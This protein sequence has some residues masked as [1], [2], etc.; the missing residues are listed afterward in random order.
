[1]PGIKEAV[2]EFCQRGYIIEEYKYSSSGPAH[3]PVFQCTLDLDLKRAGNFRATGM[4]RNKQEAQAECAGEMA[5]L[6]YNADLFELTAVELRQ[7][8][9]GRS[10]NESSFM[11]ARYTVPSHSTVSSTDAP[12]HSFAPSPSVPSPPIARTLPV[13]PAATT[14]HADHVY[15]APSSHPQSPASSSYSNFNTPGPQPPYNPSQRST[16]PFAPPHNAPE[17]ASFPRT[18]SGN[19]PSLTLRRLDSHRQTLIELQRI[20]GS[21]LVV[22]E[23]ERRA[24]GPP[25]MPAHTSRLTGKI[26]LP[27]GELPL[28]AAYTQAR[29]KD[30]DNLC[31]ES[32]LVQIEQAFA[33][34]NGRGQVKR[35]PD[36]QAAS[37]AP[38]TQ[39]ATP[40]GYASGAPPPPT[41]SYNTHAFN[42][43]AHVQNT[44]AQ[45]NAPPRHHGGY[46]ARNYGG[47]YDDG[48]YGG[49]HETRSYGQ[50]R[51]HAGFNDPRGYGSHDMHAQSYDN[52]VYAQGGGF[53]P[54][55]SPVYQG[56]WQRSSSSDPYSNSNSNSNTRSPYHYNNDSTSGYDGYNDS[57]HSG[58]PGNY[59]APP[60]RPA[61]NTPNTYHSS[62]P[63]YRHD[64][65]PQAAF[66]PQAASGAPFLEPDLQ[67]NEAVF[68]SESGADETSQSITSPSGFVSNTAKATLLLYCTRVKARPAEFQ[69][70][71]KQI[72]PGV[73]GVFVSKVSVPGHGEDFEGKTFTGVAEASR[74]SAAENLAAMNLLEQLQQ[75]DLLAPLRVFPPSQTAPQERDPNEP[76]LI[77]L[78]DHL[79]RELAALAGDFQPLPATYTRNTGTPGI[80]TAV[81]ED[82]LFGDAAGSV[83]QGRGGRAW[84]TRVVSPPTE[85]DQVRAQSRLECQLD[86][87]IQQLDAGGDLPPRFSLPTML[88]ADEITKIVEQ[89]DVT[90]VTGATGSGKTTQVPQ[91]ILDKYTQDGNGGRCHI[92]VTE[93]RRIAAIG[94]AARVAEERGET[95]GQSVGYFVRHDSQLPP[96]IAGTIVFCTSGALL[97]RLAVDPT[98]VGVTHLILDEVHERDIASDFTLTLIRTL[99]TSGK[100]NGSQLKVI[101]MSAT[102]HAERFLEYFKSAG[103]RCGG[104]TVEGQSFPVRSF[105]WHDLF[106]T[107][108][109]QA[110]SSLLAHSSRESFTQQFEDQ[111]L[112]AN[113]AALV[114]VIRF[115]IRTVSGVVLVFLP[116]WDDIRTLLSMTQGWSR[117]QFLPLHS[118][119]SMQEQQLVFSPVPAG[120]IRVILATNIAETSITIDNVEAVIDTGR[121]RE[122]SHAGFSALG[123]LTTRWISKASMMQR[124]GR[125]GRTRPGICYHMYS[126]HKASTL[127]E[128]A[129]PEIL[130]SPLY[131]TCLYIKLLELGSIRTFLSQTP[132][133]PES[134]QVSLALETLV[135]MGALEQPGEIL[136]PLGK[137]LA[138]LPIDPRYGKLLIYA[139]AFN[140]LDFALPVA[141][142]ANTRD[143]FLTMS[144]SETAKARAIALKQALAFRTSSDTVAIAA[145]YQ[146]YLATTSAKPSSSSSAPSVKT[147]PIDAMDASAVDTASDPLD[148]ALVSSDVLHSMRK[149][150]QQVSEALT[151]L[152]VRQPAV[153]NRPSGT[154]GVKFG[155]LS[156]AVSTSDRLNSAAILSALLCAALFPN[157]AVYR[158]KK[159]CITRHARNAIFHPSCV[160]YHRDPA[161]SGPMFPFFMFEEQV[162]AADEA[163]DGV[164]SIRSTTMVS[165]LAL[166]LF[167]KVTA[168]QQCALPPDVQHSHFESSPSDSSS[169]PQRS[170]QLP[171]IYRRSTAAQH[172][173]AG[174][175]QSS[176]NIGEIHLSFPLPRF[177]VRSQATA[178]Q[179]AWLNEAIRTTIMNMVGATDTPRSQREQRVIT[180]ATQLVSREWTSAFAT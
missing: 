56:G 67:S 18:A 114:D 141:A 121:V 105:Y 111:P 152:N 3:M 139:S 61:G 64:L 116:S 126:S 83:T 12:N 98:L 131:D 76:V 32:V 30:A 94:A 22:N 42:T 74:K 135:D 108:R 97:R 178:R 31:Y 169:A 25:H 78:P 33:R 21:R 109:A 147:E 132:D 55:Q 77:R 44:D 92:L 115:A 167:G 150:V 11:A 112:S 144:S 129:R 180:L 107:V 72:Y 17:Y 118:T 133:P 43:N 164:T 20:W 145:V 91:L 103:L 70:Y 113:Y 10:I 104:I 120:F 58:H 134:V 75:A 28:V 122:K 110:N 138:Q 85:L 16:P 52:V 59:A 2:H 151:N 51:Y 9:E 40:D 39:R 49:G 87:L 175:H 154:S 14:P 63:A 54:S 171:S 142:S 143:P 173:A 50:D 23:F 179:L 34:E 161:A 15:Y 53:Q 119:L 102:V 165:P 19:W 62:N 88:R 140:A 86:N 8:M 157:V 4:G 5:S 137:T 146:R 66:T 99:L 48:S 46:D 6:L 124:K 159:N 155:E 13:S 153:A 71:R 89:N 172:S 96:S 65:T 156:E 123:S 136:T 7:R 27:S 149:T 93:P 47:G 174:S 29:A 90:I 125:A 69:S 177:L 35:E 148:F 68:P 80:D 130:R 127:D 45:T 176:S 162:R 1:M 160:S 106:D 170:A 73:A 158:K 101:L 163:S 100:R 128:F 26:M 38:P 168:V 82:E 79:E 24:S 57:H 166:I 84:D 95:L 41:S 36:F 81:D 37:S 117:T 60:P